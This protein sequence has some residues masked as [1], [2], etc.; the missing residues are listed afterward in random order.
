MRR[1]GMQTGLLQD[2]ELYGSR[3]AQSRRIVIEH[4]IDLQSA[5]VQVTRGAQSSTTI[6]SCPRQNCYVSAS[7]AQHVQDI[8]R[9]AATGVFHHL[10]DAQP[11]VVHGDPIHLAHLFGG[12]VWHHY[13]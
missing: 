4:Q 2:V 10:E 1:P 13:C 8:L 7:G 9:Q 11:K 6:T 3:R 12:D 5:I